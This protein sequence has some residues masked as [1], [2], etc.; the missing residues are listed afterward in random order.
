MN[1]IQNESA[2]RMIRLQETKSTNSYL[3]GYLQSVSLPE[4]SVVAAE[5][6]TAGKGQPGNHWESEAGSNLLFSLVL[7]PDS[8]PAA[9]QFILSQIASLAVKDT[10]AAFT[11]G[12]TVKWPNDVY[13][14]DKKI[15]GML[16]ENDLSGSII[17]KSIIG[18]GLNL[19][20]KAFTSDA[21]NPVSLT[22]IT[23][24]TYDKEQVLNIFLNHFYSYYL[25]VL[26][27]KEDEIRKTYFKSLYRNDGFYPY[28]DENGKFMARI[29]DIE[30]MGYLLLRLQNGE[31]RRYAFKEVAFTR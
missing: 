3:H 24:E 12:I 19:N 29:Q 15:C 23:G 7:Y 30:P 27:E 31:T 6:Q 13:W 1:I 8:I 22:Q 5:F 16:I 4:G 20:Q 2:P 18:I 26:Q 10:L 11:D 17:T 25:Q 28:S 21:P 9:R 14:K